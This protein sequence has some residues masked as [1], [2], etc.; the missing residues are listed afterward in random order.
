MF[1]NSTLP[2]EASSRPNRTLAKVDLPQPDSPT[3]ANVSPTLASKF[4]STFAFMVPFFFT[5][6]TTLADTS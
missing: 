4:K 2:L 3:I 1:S 5:P 6:K